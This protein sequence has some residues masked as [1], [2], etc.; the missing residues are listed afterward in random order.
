MSTMSFFDSPEWFS[1]EKL[2]TPLTPAKFLIFSMPSGSFADV[3]ADF[4]ERLF[5]QHCGI[6]G[7][8]GVDAGLTFE[9]R[10]VAVEQFED[11][12]F[13]RIGVGQLVADRK[14]QARQQKRLGRIA[15]KLHV[16]R[17][18]QTRSCG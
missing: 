8:G 9:A 15:G 7:F 5:R 11:A 10:L 17:T 12:G 13:E 16:A 6:V 1:G 4:I 2:K 14:F 18:R 3:A